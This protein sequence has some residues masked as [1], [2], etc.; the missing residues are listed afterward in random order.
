MKESTF[1][2]AVERTIRRYGL[3]AG[4]ERIG[5]AVSGGADS[6]CLL[7][8]LSRL[9]PAW[10]WVL[11]V[12]HLDHQLRDEES[13]ADRRFV[14]QLAARLHIPVS[15][16]AADV[17][18]LAASSAGNLE[19]AAREARREFFRRAMKVHG[20]DRVALGHTLSD[21]AETVLF[22]FLRGSGISG[23]AGIRPL[24]RDGFIRPLLEVTRPQVIDYLRENSLEWREDSSNTDLSFARN[25]IRHE[26]LPELEKSWNPALTEVLGR[27]AELALEEEEY[28]SHELVWM[29]Q[30]MVVLQGR[31]VLV[32]LTSLEELPLAAARRVLRRAAERAK[33]SLR[34]L[35]FEHFE[36]ILELINQPEGS[37]RIQLPG[38]DV[39]RSFDWLRLAATGGDSRERN[40]SLI[41]PIPGEVELPTGR[42]LRLEV[43][44]RWPDPEQNA[45]LQRPYKREDV[46]LHLDPLPGSLELRN[47][48][49]GDEYQPMGRSRPEK[50][51]FLFQEARIPLWE[52]RD[53][54]ILLL[55]G[56]IV[57][58]RQFGSALDSAT[59]TPGKP[60][61]RVVECD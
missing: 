45:P 42:R 13:D 39:F 54:P 49:P 59:L 25:R 41:V 40:W 1:I 14:E 20:L 36:Q 21:Q 48:R 52:R 19:Q 22:R 28:W 33:G 2:Q 12:L 35:N 55:N 16:E 51:K 11:R 4:G 37:G 29:E 9:A 38:L 18:G 3:A 58:A 44:E 32:S 56:Q 6:V 5:V 46:W 24:T 53:W 15:V 27:T 61:V 8:A 31:A 57:W 23:L 50:V 60:L 7:T 47:W 17:R 30:E 34:D 43:S 26:L 10:G